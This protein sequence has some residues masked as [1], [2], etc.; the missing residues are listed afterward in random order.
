LTSSKKDAQKNEEFES[1]K[2]EFVTLVSH[3]LRSPATLV[4]GY[5]QVALDQFGDDIDPEI[6]QYLEVAR[7]NA[8]RLTR[9]IQELTDFSDMLLADSPRAG[10]LLPLGQSI[11]QVLKIFKPH[12]D[13]KQIDLRVNIP[14][15]LK[16]VEYEGESL[17]IIFRNLLSNSVKFSSVGSRIE[18]SGHQDAKKKESRV[19]VLDFAST[20][21]EEKRDHIFDDFRQLENHLTRRYE[22]MGLGLAVARRTA[23]KHGWDIVHQAQANGNV[24]SVIFPHKS[25]SGL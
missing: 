18:L 14:E 17:I 5:L 3:E 4:N 19:E 11:E 7:K 12:L 24:F 8:A 15:Q 6:K 1:L 9:I 10:N 16:K 25:L 23:R 22:G 20:I 13:A 2:A 21:P